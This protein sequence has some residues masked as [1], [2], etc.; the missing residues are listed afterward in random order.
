MV[1]DV[2]AIEVAITTLRLP[3]GDG[4]MADCC[5]GEDSFPYKGNMRVA[6]SLPSSRSLH[7]TISACPGK[8]ARMSPSCSRWAFI[9]AEATSSAQ[10]TA[11]VS[12]KFTM[13]TSYIR[14]SLSTSGASNDLQSWSA[15]I[16]ADITTILKSGLIKLCVSRVSARAVSET[17]LR[18]WYSSKITTDTPSSVGSSMS[19]RVRMPSVRTST[20]VDADTLVSKRTL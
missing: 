13:S 17:R 7:L 6:P 10:R 4:S 1:I 16:V 12:S 3:L 8:K 11:S 5:S 14:P 15:S 2:S 18:S 19:I 9:T 20:R